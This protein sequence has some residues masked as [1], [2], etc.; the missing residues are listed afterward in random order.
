MKTREKSLPGLL[1]LKN[2]GQ[3]LEDATAPVSHADGSGG[4]QLPRK[5]EDIYKCPRTN[6][7]LLLSVRHTLVRK[8]QNSQEKLYRQLSVLEH[9]LCASSFRSPCNQE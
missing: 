2:D 1:Q 4:L 5:E 9:M 7:M 8:I 6:P 3:T